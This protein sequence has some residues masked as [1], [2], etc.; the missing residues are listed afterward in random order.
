[1]L[2]V[3]H[4]LL[5]S[6]AMVESSRKDSFSTSRQPAPGRALISAVLW[7]DCCLVFP[8][9]REG[10]QGTGWDVN[11]WVWAEVGDWDT[12]VREVL[13]DRGGASALEAR[14]V[15]DEGETGAR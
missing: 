5:P 6:F 2:Q 10:A 8:G 9:L 13:K 14:Q 15:E 12:G 3:P 1:M 11:K 7:Q 4:Y